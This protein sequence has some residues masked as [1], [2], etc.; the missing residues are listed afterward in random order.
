MDA[1]AQELIA[2]LRRNPDDSEAFGGLRAHYQRVADYASL[3]NLLE[4]WAKRAREPRAAAQALYEAG[5]LVLGAL[6]DRERAIDIYERAL[7]ADPRHKETFLRLRTLFEDG[8]EMP[9][10]SDLLERQGEALEK[11]GAD[12]RKVALL[13]H[14]LGE[15]WERHFT[16]ADKAVQHYRRAFELDPSLVAAIYSAR[17]IYR[18]AGNL[19]AAATLLEKEAKAEKDPSRRLALWRELA[20]AC[21]NDLADP[22]GAAL[23]L[24]RALADAPGDLEIMNDLAHVYLSRANQTDDPRIAASD[25]MRAADLLYQ[26]SQKVDADE[27]RGYLEEALDLRPDHDGALARYEELVDALGEVTLLPA[28]W[29]A[30]LAQA[31]DHPHAAYRRRR[32]ADAYLEAGQTQY[33]ITCLE[34]L[35]DEGDPEAAEILVPLFRAAGR[36]DDA[37]RAMGIA[38]RSLPSDERLSRMRELLTAIIGRGDIAGATAYAREILGIDP[39]DT[40]AL[41]LLEDSCRLS[42]DYSPLRDALISASHVNGLS[43][44]ARKGRLLQ[45]AALCEDRLD[46]LDGAIKAWR[47]ILSL[48]PSNRDARASLERLYIER[49]RWDDL[50]DLLERDLLAPGDRETKVETLRRLANIHREQRADAAASIDA[51]RQLWELVGDAFSRDALC[52]ALIEAGA[53]LEAIPLLRK[54]I[55]DASGGTRVR[56]LQVLASALEEHV[57]DE[58][59]AFEAWAQLL[60][61][62]PNDETALSHMEAIDEAQGR[63]ERLL[64]TLSY[65]LEVSEPTERPAVLL[66]MARIADGA[67]GDFDRAA[68]LYMRAIELSPREPSIRDALAE[69][70]DR[71]E[72][73]RDLVILLRNA[74]EAETDPVLR[75]ELNRRIAHTLADRVGTEDGAAEAWRDV[76]RDRED[77]EALRFLRRHAQR[78]D[79]PEALEQILGR[80]A[81]VQGD[82]VEVRD[83][84]LLRA[85][86]LGDRLERP[87]DAIE[88]LRYVV[89][90]L[91]PDHIIALTRLASLSERV[92]DLGGLADALWRQLAHVE[93]P[94]LRVPVA[95]RLADLHEREAPDDARAIDSLFAWAQA[96]ANSE[97]PLRRLAPLLER[98][99]RFADLVAV[100][101]S[102]ADLVGDDAE[103][104]ALVLRSASLSHAELG[105]VDGA[106]Q[107]LEPRMREGDEAAEKALRELARASHRGEQLAEVYVAL[108]QSL[109]ER[110]PRARWM[111]AA[112]VYEQE[113]QDA[114]R[115]LEA[116]LR[117]FAIDLSDR[118][119]LDEAD[120]LAERANAW[121]RLTQVYETLIKR[122]ET[123]HEKVVLLLR[124]AALLDERAGATSGALDQTLR[125]CALVPL[126]D[127]VLALAEDRAP[128]ASRADELLI[129]YDK[130]QKRAADD[131]GRIEA[132]LRSLRLCEVTLRDRSRTVHYL[133]Q[134]LAL[135]VRSPELSSLVEHAVRD[136]DHRAGSAGGLLRATADIEA[137]LAEDADARTGAQLLLRAARLLSRELG[138]DDEAFTLL[139]RAASFAPS[140]EAVLDEVEAFATKT[141][142]VE[143]LDKLLATLIDEALDNRTASELLRRRGR[144]LE[145]RGEYER[146]AEVWTRLSTIAGDSG[147]RE[148]LRACLRKAGRYQDLL[149][150]LQREIQKS[151]D[152]EERLAMQKEV[153]VLW[154]R[155]LTNRWEA[156]DAWKKIGKQAPD[157]EDAREAIARL[158]Q[159]GRRAE[160]D[161][162]L[163][164][165]PTRSTDPELG[166]PSDSGEN[167]FS[168]LTDSSD[169]APLPDSSSQ[170]LLDPGLYGELMRAQAK[171]KRAAAPAKDEDEGLPPLRDQPTRQ[172]TVR[173]APFMERDTGKMPAPPPMAP[174]PIPV[175]FDYDDD[176]E[177]AVVDDVFD[178]IKDSFAAKARSKTSEPPPA[179]GLTRDTLDGEPAEIATGEIELIDDPGSAEVLDDS[180]MNELEEEIES[181]EEIDDLDEIAPR[182]TARP[183][184]GDPPPR[185]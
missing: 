81:R 158:A 26:M 49:S 15:I 111:D 132:L 119:C 91:S 16:R 102:L 110:D 62:R 139:S 152:P 84:L 58:E 171:A 78:K 28:R 61:E 161:S 72:R 42:G 45:I 185:R 19:K 83:M 29:V 68:E 31:S 55:D 51:L 92:G 60:D 125:A 126:D 151:R 24:K 38:A 159:E 10:L 85:S 13:Y 154:E 143:P 63:H 44:E 124:H 53:M 169:D 74:A 18:Q 148:R 153:A 108:A 115:A 142:R 80:L 73:Y 14:Q 170:T 135:S 176:E 165:A 182:E 130:R 25:R 109:A 140:E 98:N 23:A 33:A 150:A 123:T 37:I 89:N 95:R 70:Y 180:D 163:I 57:G 138:A 64:S 3:A 106:W 52:D 120:R 118:S 162:D 39:A 6:E 90:E 50:V 178:Q 168:D 67:L 145:G 32:L 147:A 175:S 131:A 8:A 141:N 9:R 114:S 71:A 82:P 103:A 40:E 146:A 47:G 48:E 20:H 1:T 177:T 87:H 30:Y 97:E 173:K 76:L 134:A 100:L 4:G 77:E 117:G 122:S 35:L 137:K 166:A 155:E 172:L 181:L 179:R 136:L 184:R 36:E 5:E 121:S 93:E 12:K 75:A 56:L 144:L 167:E 107:R 160:P 86:L 54:R 105:D 157:D 21:A 94:S 99:R 116:V 128:R 69:L 34:W 43:N 79:D 96:E 17:E 88:V 11:L 65:R 183:P 113:L 174:R 22:E 2:R 7:E 133:A 41:T 129:T 149:L 27:A 101:D 46:D 156:L 112:R 127:A 66:R 164:A 104:S 59:G